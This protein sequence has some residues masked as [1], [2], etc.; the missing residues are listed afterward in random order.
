MTVRGTGNMEG[1]LHVTETK[2]VVEK[3]NARFG[4]KL[5]IVLLHFPKGSCAKYGKLLGRKLVIKV[6]DRPPSRRGPWSSRR[7][8]SLCSL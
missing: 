4:T 1:F 3:V 7:A 6:L 8:R 5:D 2:A